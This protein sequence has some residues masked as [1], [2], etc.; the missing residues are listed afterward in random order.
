MRCLI[1]TPLP[2]YN[3][4]SYRLYESFSFSYSFHVDCANINSCINKSLLWLHLFASCLTAHNLLSLRLFTPKITVSPTKHINCYTTG[5]HLEWSVFLFLSLHLCTMF[6]LEIQCIFSF[7]ILSVC[8]FEY[9][10]K[11]MV[12]TIILIIIIINIFANAFCSLFYINIRVKFIITVFTSTLYR[13]GTNN[14]HT[15]NGNFCSF[16]HFCCLIS[17]Q[18][19]RAKIASY[20][21]EKRL[22]PLPFS[23]HCLSLALI[24]IIITCLFFLLCLL[25]TLLHQPQAN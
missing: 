11:A 25:P 20:G 1:L 17:S 2:L 23:L 3:T 10:L 7:L 5:L 14:T 15:R 19:V 8:L 24:H 18:C 21:L 9:R 16:L 6:T 22:L 12:I 4:N 13:S